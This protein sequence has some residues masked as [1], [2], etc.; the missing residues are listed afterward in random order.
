MTEEDGT[1]VRTF[2]SNKDIFYVELLP[3]GEIETR[4]FLAASSGIAHFVGQF[5]PTTVI[6]IAVILAIV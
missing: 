1:K 4:Q 3:S 6:I 5:L 2:F